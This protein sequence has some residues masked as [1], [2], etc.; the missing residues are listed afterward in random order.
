MFPFSLRYCTSLAGCWIGRRSSLICGGGGS[1]GCINPC[2]QKGKSFRYISVFSILGNQ[3][4]LVDL[5]VDPAFHQYLIVF[6]H[7]QG[8]LMRVKS[9]LCIEAAMKQQFGRLIEAEIKN[10]SNVFIIDSQNKYLSPR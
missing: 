2:L 6:K 10:L 8:N 1:R 3:S 4:L 9:K 7:G 5:V